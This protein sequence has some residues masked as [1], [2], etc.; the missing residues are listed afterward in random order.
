MKYIILLSGFIIFNMSYAQD[1]QSTILQFDEYLGYVKK[2]HPV[3]KQAELIIDEGQAGLMRARGAFDP[4]LEVDYERKDFKSFEY[5]DKLNA[6]FKIP[7][8]YG[9]DLKA[10]F[11]QNQGVFLNPE[12]TVP[13]DGLYSV[14]VSFS[15]AQGLLINKRMASVK[16]AK[17]FRKQAKVDRDFLVNNILF[18]AS[19][20]YF[21][22]LQAYNETLVFNDF[23][24][25]AE[26][27]FNGIKQSVRAGDLAAIDSVEARITMNNRK[28]NL[29]KARVK[30]MKS[31][32]KVSNFLWLEN[33]IP[34]ELQ[35]NV[36]PDIV[37]EQRIDD[38]LNVSDLSLEAISIESHPKLLS[39]SYKY[40][41]LKVEKRLRMN[42]LLP[43]INLEYNFLSETPEIA[44]SF[45]TAMYKSGVTIR[46]P[47]FLRKERGELKL[48]N[49]KLQD[50]EFE[51]ENT[52]LR[53]RNKINA[54][55]QEL[56]SFELQNELTKQIVD[57]YDRLLRSEERKFELG[58]SSLFLVNTREGKLIDAQLKAIEIQN[59]FLSTKASLFNSLALNP[60][61]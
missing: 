47:L 7:T 16:Q 41:S 60:N 5:Y 23:L 10:N 8:W 20:A 18:E 15:V 1:A 33:N 24:S 31:T 19:I 55:Q 57:D 59:K 6:T 4:K 48:S 38:V 9:I 40:E 44:S 54:I 13:E 25:N 50:Q 27:R 17:L 2:Y 32:L 51:I 61:L 36:V 22:W 26:M 46:F 3:V 11:E 21:E 52:K 43:T 56:V 28:L 12:A 29:E 14:G 37:N 49:L 53:I 58:E 34:V 39:L 45:N 42:M 30:L 35:N